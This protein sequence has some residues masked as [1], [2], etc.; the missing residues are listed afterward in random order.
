MGKLFFCRE[1]ARCGDVIPKYIDGKYQ[2]FYLKGWRDPKA[3][4]VKFGWHR[5]ESMDLINMSEDVPTGVRGGTGDLIRAKDGT[6]HLFAC[7]FPQGK[8]F[9]THY[10]SKDGTLDNWEYQ[11]QDTFG[12]DGVFY[13]P[14]DWRDPRIVYDEEKDEYRMYM[15]ARMMENHAQGGCVGLCVSKDLSNWE[16]REP[17]YAPMRF[18]GACEC[19]DY[20]T[21]GEYEYIVF[22]SY[23][24]LFG[25]Y[26]VMR[27]IGTD[28][29]EIPVNHRLDARA[30]YAAKTAGDRKRRFIFGWNPTK[31]RDI[32][33]FWTERWQLQ[34]YRTWDWGSDMAVHEIFQQEGGSLGVG[35]ARERRDFFK[36]T[37][38]DGASFAHEKEGTQGLSWVAEAPETAYYSMEITC[39][40]EDGRMLTHQAGFMLRGKKETGEGYFLF[41]EPGRRR[42]IFRSWLRMSEDGGKTFPYDVELETPI[43]GTADG[44]YRLEI[45]T[46]GEIGAAYVNDEAALSFRMCD[47]KEKNTAV[48]AFGKARLDKITLK[49]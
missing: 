24:T 16:Y 11:E 28:V 6:W 19:P 45:I 1:D 10:I 13:H 37:L 46:E 33:R 41:I 15:A 8:Q 25:N 21:I 22:S 48:F 36:E 42:L 34:D 31:N 17:A 26:Y 39:V 44:K 38:L 49:S 30:F 47:L 32:F 29:W 5:M 14:S 43:R 35:L 20:F 2:L 18:S 9:I 40:E 23:T 3:P 7:I 4:G 12:P 27:R